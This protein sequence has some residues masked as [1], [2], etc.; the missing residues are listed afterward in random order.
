[1]TAPAFQ[2]LTDEEDRAEFAAVG[3]ILQPEGTELSF[4]KADAERDVAMSMLLR[5]LGRAEL[6]LE[7]HNAAKAREHMLIDARYARI[8][9]PISK[10]IADL[11]V[12]GRQLALDT[13]IPG[14]AKTRHVAY[15]DY[16]SKKVPARVS[17]ENAKELVTWAKEKEP[18]MIDVKIEERV[19][20]KAAAD[21]F[22]ST[23]DLPPGCIYTPE[24][25]DPVL[26]PDLELLRAS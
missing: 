1:M 22:K 18:T 10:R 7:R 23:G 25:E 24:H 19:P 9:D 3:I 15:G 2:F 4:P 6:D 26:K 20:Q 14:K 16:G 17:I 11:N 21:Y 8:T 13:D 5:Q 12:V